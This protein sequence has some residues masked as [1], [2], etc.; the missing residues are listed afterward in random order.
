MS[1]LCIGNSHVKRLNSYLDVYNSST[2]EYDIADLCSVNYFRI[3]GGSVSCDHHLALLTSVVRRHRPQHLIQQ[4]WHLPQRKCMHR[5][6]RLS[7]LCRQTLSKILPKVQTVKKS[8]QFTRDPSTPKPPPP[9]SK[10]KITTPIKQI[11][12]AHY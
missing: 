5:P 6:S 4:P 3:S 9:P 2:T 10:S 1:T 8:K 11:V 12:Y 7:N